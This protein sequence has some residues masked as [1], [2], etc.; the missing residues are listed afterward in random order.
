MIVCE[1]A[2]AG[3]AIAIDYKGDVA[4][5]MTDLR[6]GL[7]FLIESGELQEP[8]RPLVR[9]ENRAFEHPILGKAL[10]PLRIAAEVDRV[11]V[12][13]VEFANLFAVFPGSSNCHDRASAQFLR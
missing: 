2:S 10:N 6:A 9:A 5:H 8:M 11:G 7:R 12:A 3:R 1:V 13:R 4:H